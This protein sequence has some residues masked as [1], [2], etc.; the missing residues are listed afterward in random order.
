VQVLQNHTMTAARVGVRI[1]VFGQMDGS[2]FVAGTQ[3]ASAKNKRAGS[4]AIN[5]NRPKES[6]P[7]CP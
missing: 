1:C 2:R 3:V 6:P 4:A 5:P 7:Q